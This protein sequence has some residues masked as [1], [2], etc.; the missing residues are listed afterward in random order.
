[1]HRPHIALY[2]VPQY[3]TYDRKEM[4]R[5]KEAGGEFDTFSQLSVALTGFSAAELQATGMLRIYFDE[6]GLVLGHA[7]RQNYFD[8]EL[9]PADLLADAVWGP[10]TRNLIRMWY[11]GQWKK[12]PDGW[13]HKSFNKG[14]FFSKEELSGF[15]EFNRNVDRIISPRAYT[16]GLA[17]KA[18]GINPMGA[19]EPGFASWTEKPK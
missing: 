17:W 1:M 14:N 6:L 10:L 7:I 18:A 11:L 4:A 2:P 8:S 19:K 13:G 15:D 12:L 9:G 5:N 16:E 3:T